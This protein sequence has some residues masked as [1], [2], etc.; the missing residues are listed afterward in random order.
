[1]ALVFETGNAL[2]RVLGGAD[3][4]LHAR[5]HFRRPSGWSAVAAV[6]LRKSEGS[7]SYRVATGKCPREAA[8]ASAFPGDIRPRASG[9]LVHAGNASLGEVRSLGGGPMLVVLDRTLRLRAA[10]I[11][12]YILCRLRNR[13]FG[14]GFVTIPSQILG[15]RLTLPFR[16]SLRFPRASF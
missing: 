3:T 9:R 14:V 16:R 11:H 6:P 15:E 5:R 4:R 13:S 1:M 12:I 7:A 2:S 8:S 10:Y